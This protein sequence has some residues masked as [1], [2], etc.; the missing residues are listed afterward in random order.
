[1]T[2]EHKAARKRVNATLEK[3]EMDHKAAWKEYLS[4][5]EKHEKAAREKYEATIKLPGTDLA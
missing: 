1:M 5:C 4:S 2:A 3:Y